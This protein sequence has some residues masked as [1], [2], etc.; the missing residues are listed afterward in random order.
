MDSFSLS[1][2]PL[3]HRLVKIASNLSKLIEHLILKRKDKSLCVCVCCS[4][5]CDYVLIKFT[6]RGRLLIVLFF[7]TLMCNVLFDKNE[8]IWDLVINKEGKDKKRS[9]NTWGNIPKRKHTRIFMQTPI[10]FTNP[11]GPF[12]PLSFT[13]FTIQTNLFPSDKKVILNFLT[14]YFIDNLEKKCILV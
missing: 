12:L 7:V 6:R 5:L 4:S 10:V 8:C 3:D 11:C 1:S 14:L 13:L 2:C 9:R